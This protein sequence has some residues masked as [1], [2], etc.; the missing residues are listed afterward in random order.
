[1]ATVAAT[2]PPIDV[3]ILGFMAEGQNNP[4]HSE[5][6]TGEDF[7]KLHKLPAAWEFGPPPHP[8]RHPL[9]AAVWFVTFVAGSATLV[10]FVAILA[11]IPG[12]N[13]LALGWMLEAEGRVARSGRLRDGLPWLGV[14]PRLGAAAL[15]IW[16]WLVVVRLVAA[17][18]DDAA[19]IDPGSQ[20]AAVWSQARFIV[21]LAV[22]IHI[23]L[24]LAA[25]PSLAAFFRP[26]RNIRRVIAAA[27]A[28]TLWETAATAID[29]LLV[30]LAPAATFRLGLG[31]FLGGLAWVALPTL[32]FASARVSERPAAPLVSVIGG[33]L[34]AMT[35]MWVPFLQARYAATGRVAAFLDLAEV[36]E[37][38]RRAPV[39]MLAALVLLLGLTLPLYLLKVVVPPRDA[40]WLLTPLFVVLILPG[41][42]AVGL[43]AARAAGR[44][45]RA[46]IGTR[47]L[48][49]VVG[50]VAIGLYLVLLFLAPVLD[51]LGT[52]VL[53]DHHAV[54]LPTPFL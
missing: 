7:S 13:L 14:V 40:V 32:L 27:R 15:G 41:R 47:V 11:A 12:L 23:V 42:L 43:A 34:L 26:V 22:G 3:L 21:A 51:A 37:W 5:G 2:V 20:R 53:F 10:I 33:V 16:A 4:A 9:Q 48:A 44:T 35:L 50:W 18:A 39:A 19:L 1:M 25:G 24:A 54:L 38:F 6:T 49:G 46:W 31:G 8:L 45:E 29:R 36:R 30:V 28:G 17:V 52:R